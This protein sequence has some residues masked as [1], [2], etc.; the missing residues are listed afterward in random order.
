VAIAR[1]DFPDHGTISFYIDGRFEAVCRHPAHLPKNRC[2]LTRTSVGS[3]DSEAQGRPLGLMAAWL[4]AS[5]DFASKEEHNNPF[6]LF[7]LDFPARERARQRLRHLP[8]AAQLLDAERV[9]SP[10][11]GPEPEGWA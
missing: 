4:L 7:I 9:P 2:R 5:S 1:I 10:N 8:G 11:E 6:A 3:G